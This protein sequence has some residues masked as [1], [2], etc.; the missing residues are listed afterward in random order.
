MDSVCLRTASMEWSVPGRYGLHGELFFF[1]IRKEPALAPVDETF[2][3]F[4]EADIRT[5]P[6]SA[7]VLK[8][9]ALIALHLIAQEGRGEVDGCHAPGLGD[10]WKV[11]C[12][13]SPMWESEGEA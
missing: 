1:L 2:S 6:F 5:S 4:C 10:E 9:C 8:K 3:P 7:E 11:G 13:K 12:P